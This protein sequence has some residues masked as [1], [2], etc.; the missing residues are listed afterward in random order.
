MEV[1]IKLLN[2]RGIFNTFQVLSL[3]DNFRAGKYAFYKKLNEFS[4][5][6]SFLRVK[7]DLIKNGLLNIDSHNA[8]CFYELT[9]KGQDVFA[10][11]KKID[12][13]LK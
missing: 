9:S 10:L 4:Y 6:N 8:S 5:Y 11:L 7:D 3:F 1:L 13:I 12:K 2:K